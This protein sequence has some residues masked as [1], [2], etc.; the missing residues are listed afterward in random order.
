MYLSQSIFISQI[1]LDSYVASIDNEM[2]ALVRGDA[3]LTCQHGN[4][5]NYKFGEHTLLE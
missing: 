2:T 3:K 5:D 1:A 4:I